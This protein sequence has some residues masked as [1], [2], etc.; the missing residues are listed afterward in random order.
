[1]K[2]NGEQRDFSARHVVSYSVGVYLAVNAVRDLFLVVDGPDC[3]YNRTQYLQGNHDYLSTLTSVGGF[4]RVINTALDPARVLVSRE[5]ELGD[6]LVQ[7]SGE[8]EV[9]AALITSL[10]LASVLSI[11]YDRL[12]A[13]ARRST[14]KPVLHVPGK[15]LSDDWLGGYAETLDVLAGNISLEG[16]D[17]AEEKL[18]VVGHLFD[19]NEQDCLGNVRELKRLLRLLDLEPV[20]VWP[21]GGDFD[22]LRRIKDAG[23]ILSLP[24]GRQAA[25]TLAGRLDARLVE[26]EL[27]FGL[28]ASESWMRQVAAAFGREEQAKAVI[29][30]EL[31]K[32]LPSLEWVVPFLFQERRFGYIG[33]PHLLPGFLDMV[34]MFGGST[35]FAVVT[36]FEHHLAGFDP[37]ARA[38]KVLI[39][40]RMEELLEF[41]ES[42]LE[43]PGV[44]CLVT[45]STCIEAA[46]PDRHAVVEFGFPSYNRHA[47]YDRPSLGFNGF[48]AFADTLANQMRSF[49]ALC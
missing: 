22:D 2:D 27:P 14:A 4:H 18:A 45:N 3:V 28:R 10:P 26:L 7:V 33:D 29:A 49:M 12:C 40:P 1:V 9:G 46:R 43:A 6:L 11:D 25:R 8:T 44:D 41:L 16:A 15:S 42:S 47:L 31:E 21:D 37:A 17:P 32:V 23:T 35:A 48:L 19:R 5:K 20:A 38:A 34:E 24:Y 36:N 13:Q 30:A 39:E